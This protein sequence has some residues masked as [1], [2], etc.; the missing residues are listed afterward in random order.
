MVSIH[1]KISLYLTEKVKK[2]M[3]GKALQHMVEKADS[4]LDIG[5]AA[6]VDI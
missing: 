4:G 6:A 2:A 3:L 1:I 5:F